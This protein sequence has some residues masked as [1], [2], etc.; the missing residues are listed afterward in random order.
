MTGGGAAAAITIPRWGG[1]AHFVCVVGL[2]TGCGHSASPCAHH[3]LPCLPRSCLATTREPTRFRPGSTPAL[4][5][6]LPHV[7]I[8]LLAPCMWVAF[9]LDVGDPFEAECSNVAGFIAECAILSCEHRRTFSFGTL[10][11]WLCGCGDASV[12][13]R[14]RAGS[15]SFEPL[16]HCRYYM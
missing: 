2:L 7:Y 5:V 3:T 11:R 4:L 10:V 9:H 6:S 14:V 13:W 16:T 8:R 1:A 15:R 12:L